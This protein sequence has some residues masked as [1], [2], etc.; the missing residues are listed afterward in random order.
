MPED[1]RNPRLFHRSALLAGISAPFFCLLSDGLT[2]LL[3]GPLSLLQDFYI[4]WAAA[5]VLN[6]GGNPY[7]NAALTAVLTPEHIRVVLGTGYSYPLLLAQALRPIGSLD[8]AT[9]GAIFVAA[10]S[11]ALGVAV[12]LLVGSVRHVRWFAAIPLGAVAGLAP[13]ISFGMFEGQS[14]PLILPFL[15]LAY[16]GVAPGASIAVATAVKLYPVAGLSALFIKRRWRELALGVTAA[17]VLIVGPGL[18]GGGSS[19]GAQ[20]TAKV[21]RLLAPDAYFTNVSINGFLSRAVHNPLWPLRAVP[22]ELSDIFVVALLGALV[23]TVAL[24]RRG[25]SFEGLLSLV[26]WYAT[27]SAPKNSLWNMAPLL[28]PLAYVSTAWRRH[29]VAA[30]AAFAGVVLMAIEVFVWAATNPLDFDPAVAYRSLPLLLGSG[31]AL[32][33]V[34]VIGGANVAVLLGE[35]S[36]EGSAHAGEQLGVLP[37]GDGA[38]V[39]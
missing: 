34:L 14:N 38:G 39:Q 9:A 23:L 28:L 24:R 3:R 12:A 8:P 29:P 20:S 30:M 18:L 10:C 19:G 22:V 33:G 7:D 16:R 13:A 11:L 26:T 32:L 6:A 36:A 37:R 31:I 5:R 2:I 17:A 35:N 15:A 4:F 21:G 1:E 25:A 27:V